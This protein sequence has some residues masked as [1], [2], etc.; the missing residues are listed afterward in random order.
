MFVAT[1]N[2]NRFIAFR[3]LFNARFYY[4]ILGIF[5]LD[6][7]L[8]LAQYGLLN[9]A[10]A[11]AIV[12]LEIPSGAVADQ[13]G[14]KRMVVL[15]S[16]LMI[17]EIGIM[18][19][20]PAGNTGLLF[21]LLLLNRILSGAAEASASG[22]D[23]ALV[24]DSLKREGREAE[25]PRVLSRLMRWQS[26]AFFVTMLVGAT[27][28]DSRTLQAAAGSIGLDVSWL[29]PEMT[30][31]FPVYLTLLNAIAAF[32][33]VLGM[34]EHH[35]TMAGQQHV[36]VWSTLKQTA[37][38]ARWIWQTSSALGLLLA[39]L[40]FDSIL[41]LFLTF[42]ANYYRLIGLPEA[43][44]GILGALF[45]LLGFAAGPLAGWLVRSRGLV[46]NF[47]IVA[48]L[49]LLGL[50][51]AAFA[52]PVIGVWVII[53]IGL[54][55]FCTSFFL[56]HYLNAIVPEARRATVLSF[57]GLAFN[58]GYGGI[59]LL[60]S[61]LTAW[62]TRRPGAPASSDAVFGQA[63]WWL[64]GYFLVTVL[65]LGLVVLAITRVGRAR[66][67]ASTPTPAPRQLSSLPNQ[68]P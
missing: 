46:F 23:E 14:R 67:V 8:S 27:V 52:V 12:C 11:L 24:F 9:V 41:R 31:R 50:L 5:F 33:V 43:S 47:S 1:T 18:A 45:G 30:A 55:M 28:Y 15:A 29:T 3:V 62:L 66:A 38:A 22:A 7:G 68:L 10:W 44:F 39:G 21:G 65:L 53:P 16:A 2:V 13:L 19:F 56:A 63:L 40:C 49:A 58:M 48:A 4:P 25:W 17:V 42:N 60:Y 20:A 34:S 36:T 35:D 59:G 61:G 32:W 51:G 26:A 6:L 54:A 37:A 64:P 57:R